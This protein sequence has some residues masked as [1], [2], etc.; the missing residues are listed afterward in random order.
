MLKKTQHKIFYLVTFLISILFILLPIFYQINFEK[1]QTF[2]LLGVLVL[3]FFGSATI[4]LPTPTIISIGVAGAYYNPILV[5]LFAAVGSTLGDGIGYILGYSSNKATNFEDKK[6]LYGLL[7]FTLEKYG[8]IIILLFAIIPNP[9]FDGIGILAG[10]GK[11]P[12]N[13]FLLLV[14]LGRLLRFYLVALIGNS[15]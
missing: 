1:F 8:V 12:I 7:H 5:G 13:K 14:F 4:F 9:F 3:S 10:I 15:V 11:Y 6:I 2:G